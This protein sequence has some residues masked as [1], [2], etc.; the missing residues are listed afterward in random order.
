VSTVF[1]AFNATERLNTLLRFFLLNISLLALTQQAI[2][3]QEL[4][5]D[6]SNDFDISLIR[7][8]QNVDLSRLGKGQVGT[9]PGRYDLDIIVNGDGVGRF[10]LELQAANDLS[11]LKPCI[12]REMLRSLGVAQRYLEALP[13]DFDSN[14]V[15]LK[16]L[17]EQ[18][19]AALEMERLRLNISIPQMYLE[20]I[21]RGYVDSSYWDYGVNAG[22][23]NYQA[24]ARYDRNYGEGQNNF[25]L[26]LSN[27]VNLG[28]WRFRNDSSLMHTPSQG[29]KFISNQT[30]VQRDVMPWRSQVSAG[31]LYSNGQVFDSVRFQ[32]LQLSSDEGML[33]DSERGYAPVVRGVAETNATVEVRQ[34]GYVLSST[35]VPPGPFMLQNIYPSGSN[36]DLEIT[37]IETDG[38]RRVFVQPFSALP[39]MVRKGYLRYS[40]E[41]GR[42]KTNNQALETPFFASM[43]STYGLNEELSLTT[44]LQVA[45]GFKALNLGVG[46]NTPVGAVSVDVTQSFSSQQGKTLKGQSLRGLFAKTLTQTNTTVTLAAYRYST[47]GYRSFDSHV[48]DLYSYSNAYAIASMHS[49]ARLDL[50]VTQSLGKDN[51][52]GNFYVNAQREAFWNGSTSSSL[53]AGYGNTWR[54]ISYQLSLSHVRNLYG[55]QQRTDNMLTLSLSIPLGRQVNAPRMSLQY[56]RTDNGGNM[57]ASIFGQMPGHEDVNLSA[58][59]ARNRNHSVSGSAGASVDLP[60]LALGASLGAGENYTSTSMSVRGAVVAHAGGVNFSR[61]VGDGFA[62]VQVKGVEGVGVGHKLARTASNGYAVYPNIQ[63]Y[64]FNTISLDSGALGADVEL[65]ALS[66]TVVPHR[67]AIVKAEFNGVLGRRVQ[68][69]LTD[70]QGQR[71]P[72]GAEVLDATGKSLGMVD[73][74]GQA[75]ILVTQDQGELHMAWGDGKQCQASYALPARIP[76]RYYDKLEITCH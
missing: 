1:H 51:R 64:R 9:L 73:H 5:K 19:Y 62:L 39:L 20:Q 46:G 26:G 65:D 68:L 27:G 16:A 30:F 18:A 66:K 50:S 58:Q 56:D 14:C 4:S 45:Q 59:I 41:V 21:R 34:N 32:G 57:Q 28:H 48:R 67:G 70:V 11:M 47:L 43:S 33:A 44:G 15:N 54:G 8:G 60:A 40:A 24:N 7:G 63:P 36:G 31:E 17:D 37:V 53:S 42:Y 10:N 74:H 35:Q 69:R 61:H 52:Y 22:F 6:M 13:Q 25:F 3:A 72:L 71:L 23:I 49:K 29:N 38:R 76:N 75:L 2:Q 12:T 55:A